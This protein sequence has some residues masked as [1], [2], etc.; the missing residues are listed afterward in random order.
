MKKVMRMFHKRRREQKTD[1]KKRLALLKSG[2]PRL[3][4]RKSLEN[5]RV[6]IVSFN[7]S[8]DKTVASAFSAE[9]GEFGWK[10]GNG[11]LPAA[12]LT[13]LLAGL[14]AKRQA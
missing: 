14:R 11:N 12:Y 4:I 13:G 9:L 7:P 1:Y 2:V 5:M 3:V 6:Q 8:G 10:G